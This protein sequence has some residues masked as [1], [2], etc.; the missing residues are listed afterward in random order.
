MDHAP[1]EI[2]ALIR[3]GEM[4]E[5]LSSNTPWYCVSCYQ[6]M[7]RCP[8]QIPVTDM[9]YTL[10]QMA[11]SQGLIPKSQKMPD[12]YHAFSA[13]I[14]R[15]GRVTESL[16]MA[17]YGVRHPLELADNIPL[18]VRLFL[19]NRLLFLPQQVN[20]RSKLETILS[21]KG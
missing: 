19:R 13:L 3:D 8:R 14:S 16:V 11:L 10:K 21:T 18:A 15:F 17:L 4:T 2:F 12:M 7:A 9:M 20:D 5:V 6:C 1:R